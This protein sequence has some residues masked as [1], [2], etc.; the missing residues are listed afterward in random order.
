MYKLALISL[1]TFSAHADIDSFHQKH[2]PSYLWS[3]L[4]AT[5]TDAI[6]YVKHV[7]HNNLLHNASI[8]S[9][10]SQQAD[11]KKNETEKSLNNNGVHKTK[12]ETQ[13]TNNIKYDSP[14]GS[15][16]FSRDEGEVVDYTD[17]LDFVEFNLNEFKKYKADNQYYM[18][19]EAMVRFNAASSY[20]MCKND[21][22]D[23]EAMFRTAGK[24]EFAI[25]EMLSSEDHKEYMNFVNL[26]TEIANQQIT[27]FDQEKY[28]QDYYV[29]FFGGEGK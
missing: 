20:L 19:D 7:N 29:P 14:I 8:K 15:I 12:P 24:A 13:K 22:D 28:C 17:V 27:E 6:N 11:V 3:D 21:P 9:P 23:L 2:E 18:T 5:T 16:T 10:A 26:R 4:E 25:V 1:L